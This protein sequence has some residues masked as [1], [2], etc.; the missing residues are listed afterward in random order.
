[1]IIEKKYNELTDCMKE[2]I[3]LCSDQISGVLKQ[4]KCQIKKKGLML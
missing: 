2:M 1:M 3:Y 4:S